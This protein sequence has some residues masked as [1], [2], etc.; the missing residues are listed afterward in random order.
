MVKIFLYLSINYEKALHFFSGIWQFFLTTARKAMKTNLGGE[1]SQ[2]A[3]VECLIK[4][5]IV[6]K[7]SSTCFVATSRGW[8]IIFFKHFFHVEISFFL[9]FAATSHTLVITLF[10]PYYR[11]DNFNFS[12]FISWALIVLNIFL[13]NF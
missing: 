1:K 3:T 5:F 4:N 6:V 9:P 8:K 13:Y 11:G 12:F 7:I 10:T 2:I